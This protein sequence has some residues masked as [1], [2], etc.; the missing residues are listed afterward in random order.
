[1]RTML[2]GLTVSGALALLI[3][4]L[5]AISASA[6]ISPVSATFSGSTSSVTFMAPWGMVTCTSSGFSGVTPSSEEATSISIGAPSFGGCSSPTLGPAVLTASGTWSIAY[7]SGYPS[8]GSTSATVSIPSEGLQLSF[9]SGTC[10]VRV[11]ASTVGSSGTHVWT[12][13][14]SLHNQDQPPSAQLALSGAGALAESGCFGI[15]MGAMSATY[16]IADTETPV[17]LWAGVGTYSVSPN[18]RRFPDTR[19]GESVRRSVTLRNGGGTDVTITRIRVVGDNVFSAE[20]EFRVR[21]N[22]MSPIEIRFA[23]TAVRNYSAR[24][25]FYEGE[26]LIWTVELRGRGTE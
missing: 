9:L 7:T 12:D 16:T 18:P 3:L 17:A 15:Q 1:M 5:A 21:A 23:P 10:V 13:G 6:A 2:R 20:A 26:T 11:G 24:M 8:P 25:E 19:R 4:A 14:G 22:S